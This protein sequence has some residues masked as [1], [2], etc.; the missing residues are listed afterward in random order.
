MSDD[1]PLP[2]LQKADLHPDTLREL[3]RDVA[4]HT[5]LV[6]VTLKGVA[7]QYTDERPVDLGRAEA[8]L[9]AGEVRGVQIRYRFD[10]AQWWDTLMRTPKGVRLVRIRHGA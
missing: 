1:P 8:L 2:D 4:E 9:G 7:E 10:G 6:S 3:F 5:E